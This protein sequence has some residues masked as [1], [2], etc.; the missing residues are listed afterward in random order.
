MRST[1]SFI[2]LIFSLC[3]FASA[4]Y[5][6]SLLGTFENR[7]YSL[8]SE[9]Y[10]VNATHIQIVDFSVNS[11]ID[12]PAIPFLFLNGKDKQ[13]PKNVYVYHTDPNGDW[14]QK[15]TSI[16]KRGGKSERFVVEMPGSAAQWRQFAIV[17][18][19]LVG[20][21]FIFERKM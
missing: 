11:G 15:T 5:F 4:D 17:N 2:F 21:I 16:G 8:E 19:K 18:T 14:L 1:S 13:K 10:L 9:V 6:G 12:A 3:D 7:A 20:F